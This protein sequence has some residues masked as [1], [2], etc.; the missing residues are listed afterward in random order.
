[1]PESLTFCGRTFVPAELEFMR[2]TAQ[3]FFRPRRDRDRADRLRVAGVDAAQR[4]AE[5]PR[6]PATAGATPDRRLSEASRGAEVGREGSATRRWIRGWLRAGA[7]DRRC[8]RVRASG[9]GLGRRPGGEP[10]VARA[11]RT[12]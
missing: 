7:R 10:P 8:Q 11:G 3:E 6:V 5:E 2:H 9:V 12:V 1:M 4:R